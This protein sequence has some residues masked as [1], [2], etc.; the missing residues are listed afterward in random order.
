MISPEPQEDF[1]VTTRFF[2]YIVSVSH[3]IGLL[4]LKYN[5]EGKVLTTSFAGII[6]HT[7]STCGA[8]L[9]LFPKLK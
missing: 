8:A 7:G 9:L 1:R 2:F 4:D 3:I 5:S 6:I